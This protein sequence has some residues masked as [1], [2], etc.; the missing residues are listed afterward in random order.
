MVAE[1]FRAHSRWLSKLREGSRFET[2]FPEAVPG[3]LKPMLNLLD[4]CT[5]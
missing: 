3:R 4:L 2:K 1:A 5:G